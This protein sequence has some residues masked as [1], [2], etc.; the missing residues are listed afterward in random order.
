[1]RSRGFGLSRIMLVTLISQ[2]HLGHGRRGIGFKILGIGLGLGHEN[3]PV[4]RISIDFRSPSRPRLF[5]IAHFKR[6]TVKIKRGQLRLR[7]SGE[8]P[9]APSP[10]LAGLDLIGLANTLAVHE[11]RAVCY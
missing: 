4:F 11:D 3:S 7:R 5:N 6:T 8:L 10:Y 1:M 2:P 9:H